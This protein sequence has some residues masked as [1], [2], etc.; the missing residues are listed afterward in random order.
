MSYPSGILAVMQIPMRV[1]WT[2]PDEAK[3]AAARERFQ[4][5]AEHWRD[6]LSLELEG[7]HRRAMMTRSPQE[8]AD[9]IASAYPDLAADITHFGTL[10][11]MHYVPEQ[12]GVKMYQRGG[13]D[14]GSTGAQPVKLC[15]AK[16]VALVATEHGTREMDPTRLRVMWPMSAGDPIGGVVS[17]DEL[18]RRKGSRA[19]HAMAVVDWAQ[20]HINQT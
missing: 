6:G 5:D 19:E 13:L 11:A 2:E 20:R 15:E 1:E 17:R 18:E 7:L 12:W 8:R 3:R 14:L 4:R 16:W 10:L 9:A